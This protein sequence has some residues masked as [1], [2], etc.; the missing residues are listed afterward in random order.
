MFP[1]MQEKGVNNLKA[2]TMVMRRICAVFGNKPVKDQKT[3]MSYVDY[4]LENATE[5]WVLV[6]AVMLPTSAKRVLFSSLRCRRGARR[7]AGREARLR[8]SCVFASGEHRKNAKR[9]TTNCRNVSSFIF[10][11]FYPLLEF[12]T[13][14]GVHDIAEIWSR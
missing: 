12:I 2:F 6:S 13:N 10:L 7:G 11:H 8:Q 4:I 5:D 1:Q 3:R 9:L 14:Y